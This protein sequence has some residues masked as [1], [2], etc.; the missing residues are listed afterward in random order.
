MS[1]LTLAPS[2]WPHSPA[3]E[4]Y[5]L[6]TCCLEIPHPQRILEFHSPDIGLH[7]RFKRSG[8][9]LLASL[10]A[11]APTAFGLITNMSEINEIGP[12]HPEF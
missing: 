2:P 4:H 9:L 1:A 7:L 5:L 8:G 12:D 11:F 10:C 6:R 3:D